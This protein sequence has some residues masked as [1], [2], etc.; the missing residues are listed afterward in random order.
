MVCLRYRDLV[1]GSR[2]QELLVS[3][4][5]DAVW[6]FVRVPLAASWET[7]LLTSCRWG[8]TALGFDWSESHFACHVLWKCDVS[9][10]QDRVGCSWRDADQ[11]SIARY[12][13]RPLR[14]DGHSSLVVT[15]R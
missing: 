2:V 15:K 1:G 3:A 12:F 9:S 8:A 13:W 10:R 6:A 7:V 11:H 5:K 14:R 4:G